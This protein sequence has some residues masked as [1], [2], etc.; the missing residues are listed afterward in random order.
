FDPRAR[1][2]NPHREPLAFRRVR[3]RIEAVRRQD[4]GRTT[5]PT[6]IRHDLGPVGRVVSTRVHARGTLIGNR[7]HSDASA[8]E[9]RRYGARTRVGRPALPISATTWVR[10][11]GS[12]RP[13][14]AH[15]EPSSGTARIPTRPLSNR[16]GTAPGRGSDDP[17][18]QYPPRPGSGGAGRFDPRAR[19]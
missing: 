10:W 2:W 16:G 9:S 1:T 4:A 13:A 5:R 17:P 18:Y 14:C 19:T 7:S 8:V 3:C 11:G 6:N 15:V 12:F